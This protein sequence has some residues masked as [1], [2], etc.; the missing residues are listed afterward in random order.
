MLPNLKRNLQIF[1]KLSL[2][3]NVEEPHE[4]RYTSSV[5]LKVTSSY[6]EKRLFQYSFIIFRGMCHTKP[7]QLS[8]DVAT[9]QSMYRLGDHWASWLNGFVKLGAVLSQSPSE[10][11]VESLVDSEE[12][13]TANIL[14]VKTDK[15]K[16][17]VHQHSKQFVGN[18]K[19]NKNHGWYAWRNVEPTEEVRW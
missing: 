1:C 16:S 12:T 6:P 19:K 8:L 17:L 2:D 7:H 14:L 4:Q 18:L 3:I 10:I 15:F 9:S 11:A 13:A 5:N